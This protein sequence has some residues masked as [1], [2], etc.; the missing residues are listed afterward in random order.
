MPT[1]GPFNGATIQIDPAK[2]DVFFTW[3]ADDN[4]Q[5]AFKL[6][7]VDGG[8]ETLIASGTKPC[9]VHVD[10]GLNGVAGDHLKW[11]ILCLPLN[12]G[13]WPVYVQFFQGTQEAGYNPITDTA[14]Y[15]VTVG[16]GNFTIKDEVAFS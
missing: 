13:T 6:I 15:N 9:A 12:A 11:R 1:R 7:H 8:T 16:P 10:F 5:V 14:E 4:L 3:A 2:G